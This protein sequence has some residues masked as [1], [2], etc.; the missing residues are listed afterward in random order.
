[1]KIE[2]FEKA[3]KLM[4]EIKELKE[5]IDDINF[6]DSYTGIVFLSASNASRTVSRN[7]EDVEVVKLV[8]LKQHV[9][10]LIK[11]EAELKA[12]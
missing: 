2:D 5:L 11:L 7:K 4:E 10:K 6:S 12:L 1:M 9:T 8:L 3:A